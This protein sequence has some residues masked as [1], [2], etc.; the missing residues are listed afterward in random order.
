MWVVACGLTRGR[1]KERL[2][3]KQA[4]LQD[5]ILLKPFPLKVELSAGP[6]LMRT[7]EGRRLW[8]AF[9]IFQLSH[10]PHSTAFPIPAPQDF[11]MKCLRVQCF[12]PK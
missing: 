4:G 11:S 10:L 5:L 3:S 2:R 9:L 1:E 6:T 12:L 8:V 7:V